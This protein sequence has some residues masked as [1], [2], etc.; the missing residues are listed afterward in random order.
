[1]LS[2]DGIM[3]AELSALGQ[4]LTYNVTWQLEH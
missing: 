4:T 3:P 2:P 1:M